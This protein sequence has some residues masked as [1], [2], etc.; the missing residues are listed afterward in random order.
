M[1]R[2]FTSWRSKS[3]SWPSLKEA[4]ARS[5]SISFYTIQTTQRTWLSFHTKCCHKRKCVQLGCK[6]EAT[7]TSHQNGTRR[8]EQEQYEEVGST[9]VMSI[10]QLA[11]THARMHALTRTH[12]CTKE[13]PTCSCWNSS[14]TLSCSSRISAISPSKRVIYGTKKGTE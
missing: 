2:F 10:I 8:L 1:S 5:V 6:L 9:S 14:T 7:L 12:A 3:C 4:S 11:N 13:Q